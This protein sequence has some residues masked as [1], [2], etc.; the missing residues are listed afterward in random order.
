MLRPQLLRRVPK[1]FVTRPHAIAVST[2]Q[3]APD[4]DFPTPQR[5]IRKSG[6]TPVHR[7]KCCA[8]NYRRRVP[9][10]FVTR[11]HAIAVSTVQVAPDA[12]FLRRNEQSES[13]GTLRSTVSNVA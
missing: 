10:F 1:F 6:D 7:L 13:L 5:T 3:V 4:A 9:K 2:V 12:D 8:R 11:P